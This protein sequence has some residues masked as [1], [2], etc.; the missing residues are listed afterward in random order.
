MS[1]LKSN[2]YVSQNE[3]MV[4]VTVVLEGDGYADAI[5]N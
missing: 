2:T 4:L 1:H 3:V 5:R